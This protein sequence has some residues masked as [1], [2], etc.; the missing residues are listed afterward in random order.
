MRFR[1]F[2][3]I[4]GR[5]EVTCR[6]LV[7]RFPISQPTISHH[8]KVLTKAGLVTVR[9]AGSYHLYRAR[10]DVLEEHRRLLA[11][12]G[13]GSDT[14]STGPRAPSLKRAGQGPAA[15]QERRAP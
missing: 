3:E 14:A 12:V 15:R 13:Q 9:K 5:D 7:E 8:I 6:E 2:R 10:R 4:A 11:E 1:L